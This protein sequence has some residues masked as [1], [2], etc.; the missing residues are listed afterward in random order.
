MYEPTAGRILVD[1]VDLRDVATDELRAR[2]AAAFQDF[3]TFELRARDSVGIGDL[4]RL[5]DD[6]VVHAALERGGGTSLLD[7]LPSGLDTNLGTSFVDGVSLSGGQWQKVA[8]SRAMARDA[9]L[10]LV[11][12]EPTASL[13]AATEHA[14]FQRYAAAARRV[15]GDRGTVTVLVTHRY[16]AARVADLIVVLQGGRVV[17]VGDHESLLRRKGAYAEVYE[18]QARAFA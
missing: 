14:L 16:S 5:G 18:L 2:Y 12:D 17:E 1:G 6:D 10:V 8:I 13:D 11:L 15:G 9:P 7:E 3:V 4:E